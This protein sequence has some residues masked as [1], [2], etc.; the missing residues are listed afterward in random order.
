MTTLSATSAS[1]GTLAFS[2]LR[3]RKSWAHAG[4][5]GVALRLS[6]SALSVRRTV[7]QPPPTT[8]PF[9]RVV[10]TPATSTAPVEAPALRGKRAVAMMSSA[11]VNAEL[12]TAGPFGA[13]SPAAALLMLAALGTAHSGGVQVDL[14]QILAWSVVASAALSQLKT[15]GNSSPQVRRPAFCFCDSLRA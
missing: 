8:S 5:A 10:S 13:M 11:S 15:A 12:E 2:S 6:V 4:K 14:Q 1:P 3:P 7:H 9:G